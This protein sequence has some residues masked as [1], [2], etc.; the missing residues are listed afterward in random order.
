MTTVLTATGDRPISLNLLSRWMK[1]QNI[2]PDK[3]LIIDDGKIPLP[4]DDLLDFPEYVI[5]LRREPQR[6]DPKH[7]L[8]INIKTAL[9]YITGDVL[10]FIEDDEYYAPKYIETM[11]EKIQEHEIVGLCRSKYYNLRTSRYYVNPNLGHASLAQTGLKTKNLRILE[12]VIDGDAFIDTRL[13]VAFG[14]KSC[15][16]VK[17][18]VPEKGIQ[19]GNGKGILFDDGLKDCLYVGMKGMPGRVGIGAGH[20]SNGGIPD[21]NNE[22][23]KLW[24]PNDCEVY[25]GLNCFEKTQ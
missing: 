23:L 2:Q 25:L 9:K 19:V 1:N 8:G 6:T 5:Y 16:D 14:G 11:L 10:L 24:M 13:W 12:S 15:S 20:R 7:T 18:I 3:W 4:Y 22:V 17:T 21:K